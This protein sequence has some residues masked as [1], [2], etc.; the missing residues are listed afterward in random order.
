MIEEQQT[1]LKQQ[2]AELQKKI[3]K[4]KEQQKAAQAART[5]LAVSSSP[6]APIFEAAAEWTAKPPSNG[7]PDGRQPLLQEPGQ[8]QFQK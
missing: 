7:H 1:Q 6:L 8:R 4:R 2:Y 5:R 3:N